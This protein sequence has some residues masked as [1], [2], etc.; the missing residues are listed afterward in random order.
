MASADASSLEL[1]W[2]AGP[3]A[4]AWKGEGVP[5]VEEVIASPPN[6]TASSQGLRRVRGEDKASASG[7]ARG[8]RSQSVSSWASDFLGGGA[9]LPM[10]FV[11]QSLSGLV[12]LSRCGIESPPSVSATYSVLVVP[13]SISPAAAEEAAG[14]SLP[15]V[16]EVWDPL[17][18]LG[19]MDDDGATVVQ[20]GPSGHFGRIA[21]VKVAVDLAMSRPRGALT[22]VRALQEVGYK[23]LRLPG[24]GASARNSVEAPEQG[25][26]AEPNVLSGTCVWVS[27]VRV[28]EAAMNL[29]SKTGKDKIDRGGAVSVQMPKKFKSVLSSQES[30]AEQRLRSLGGGTV[31]FRGLTL[32]VPQEQLRPRPSSGALVDAGLQVLRSTDGGHGRPCVLDLGTGS[33]ALL[34]ALLRELG[35]E[36]SGHGVDIDEV[37]VRTC[38]E[39]AALVLGAGRVGVV[40]ADFTKLDDVAVRSQLAQGGYDVI[41]C[42]PPYRS[43]EQQLAYDRSTGHFG[44][45]TEHSKTL[46]AGKT[47]LE[48]YEGIARCLARD[49]AQCLTGRPEDFFP[50]LKRGGTLIFQVEAGSRGTVGGMAKVV[51]AV[52]E[53]AADGRLS[54]AGIHVDDR[55]LERAILVRFTEDSAGTALVS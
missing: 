48:M 15:V 53:R 27:S 23:V 24:F 11:D 32:K 8:G 3:Y 45:N 21:V 54:V 31:E 4:V 19:D 26:D 41:V 52:V 10:S 6:D 33:G 1:V 2:R 38:L 39:N 47:G 40:L 49:F 9:W 43:E 12:L 28:P 18:L 5:L 17:G 44:G 25:L 36:A 13:Q 34:L 7:R 14:S 42:N 22:V 50:V 46:V 20:E 37:A 35:P 16:R 30:L 29:P 51:G 55:G